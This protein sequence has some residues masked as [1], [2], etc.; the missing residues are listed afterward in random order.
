[1]SEPNENTFYDLK[2]DEL[3]SFRAKPLEARKAMRKQQIQDILST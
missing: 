1:M 3:I 2:K